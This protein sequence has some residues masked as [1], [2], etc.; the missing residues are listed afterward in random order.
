MAIKTIHYEYLLIHFVSLWQC[1]TIGN[2]NTSLCHA[3]C[4]IL[5]IPAVTGYLPS[6]NI[7]GICTREAHEDST[8]ASPGNTLV[9][10]LSEL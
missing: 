1:F 6:I 4:L 5:V 3:L 8:C 9:I 7:S 2:L 10:Q